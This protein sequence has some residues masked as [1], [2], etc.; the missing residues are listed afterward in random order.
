MWSCLCATGT[1]LLRAARGACFVPNSAFL[2]REFMVVDDVDSPKS[3]NKRDLGTSE[4]DERFPGPPLH[5]QPPYVPYPQSQRP[6][7]A[8]GGQQQMMQNW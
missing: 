2:T 5:Q 3:P 1:R 7:W 6:V 4:E 8:Q